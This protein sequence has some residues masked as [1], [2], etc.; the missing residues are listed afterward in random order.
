MV[1]AACAPA[2][3]GPKVA[4][5]GVWG[6]PSPK[7]ATAGAFYMIFKNAGNAADTLV[8]ASSTACGTVEMHETV[9]KNG[10]MEMVPIPGQKIEVPAGGEVV[11]KPGGTHIMCIDK[12]ADFAAGAKIPLTLTFEKSG[13]MKF[14]VEIRDQ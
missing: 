9:D 14:D 13:E 5:E 7:I 12:K 11:L 3:A 6:R 4:V 8:K 2:V 10:M 1:L